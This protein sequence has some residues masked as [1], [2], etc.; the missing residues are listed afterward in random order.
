[1]R[2]AELDAPREGHEIAVASETS[3]PSDTGSTEIAPP[4]GVEGQRRGNQDPADAVDA[5]LAAALSGAS[6]AGRFD[7]VALL[8]NELQARRLAR[9]GVVAL[10]PRRRG[11]R[12]VDDR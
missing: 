8:A 10:D 5:A 7:V 12:R 4:H 1:M 9:G 3:P 11:A 2:S 6:A